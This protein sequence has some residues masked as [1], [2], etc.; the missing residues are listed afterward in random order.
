M[1]IR[2]EDTTI[3]STNYTS[4]AKMKAGYTY[5]GDVENYFRIAWKLFLTETQK[6]IK[7]EYQDNGI[8]S[9]VS[10]INT[11]FTESFT[12]DDYSQITILLESL[13]PRD[14]GEDI[15]ESDAFAFIQGNVEGID[16]MTI[17]APSFP[18]ILADDEITTDGT[19]TLT[20]I[21]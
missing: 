10:L 18:I 8:S 11:I 16:Y 14:I 1:D 19:P 21:P 5:S 17:A 6:Q 7:E 20:E 9:A 4:A 13:E 12:E 3:T 15:E 2:V